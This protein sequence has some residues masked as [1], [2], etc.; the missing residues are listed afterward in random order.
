MYLYLCRTC[1][2]KQHCSTKTIVVLHLFRTLRSPGTTKIENVQIFYC[3]AWDTLS[4]D[5]LPLSDV[6]LV[7]DLSNFK[8]YGAAYCVHVVLTGLYRELQNEFPA[9]LSVL[10]LGN[11]SECYY[12]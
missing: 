4:D 11:F 6:Y 7:L 1:V 2:L 3:D 10:Y 8:I 12:N 5:R 9:D